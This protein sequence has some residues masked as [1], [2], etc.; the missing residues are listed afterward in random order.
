M[1]MAQ[2]IDRKQLK[3]EMKELLRSA[4]VSPWGMTCLYLGLV[5]VLDLADGFVTSVSAGLLGTFVSILTGLMSMV[6]AS[7]FVMYCMAIRRGERAEYLTLFDG[8]S[9]VGRIILLN[10]VEYL[11]I[12][13]WSLLFVIPGI[14][15]AY[16]YRFALYDLYENP[17][18]G[19]MEAL[20]MS[21][22]Q[23]LGY[24]GQLFLL[25]L[26][27]TGWY[28]LASLPALIQVGYIYA[29]VFQDPGYFLADPTR[30]YALSLPLPLPVQVLL[31]CLWPLAV[32]LF[33]LPVYQCT[34]LGYFDIAKHTSGVSLSGAGGPDQPD[35]GGWGGF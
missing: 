2:L 22:Q 9:F 26:S 23:T 11:F 25:D 33:Y 6:L 8:F 12:F 16:R 10:I 17:G 5:L 35:G 7:G 1:M 14:I 34:E 15:A 27:Y 32:A 13:L 28:L 3:R 31:G 24:K 18:I 30:V 29:A 21:K 19:V 20:E 4:Q